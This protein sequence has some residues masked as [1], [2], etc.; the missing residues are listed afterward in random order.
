M[1]YWSIDQLLSELAISNI[2]ELSSGF[3]FRGLDTVSK[4]KVFYIDTD[5]EELIASKKVILQSL[6]SPGTNLPG[7]LELSTL[8]ALNEN[9][10]I[11]TVNTFPP[12]AIV[13][14]NEGLLMY[15]GEAEKIKLC[16]VI[17]KVLTER[18]GYWITGD[19]YRRST[20]EKVQTTTKD[21]LKELVDRQ[22][23]E[24]NMFDN[25][26]SAETFFSQQGFTIDKVAKDNFS[27]ISSLQYL[28][29]NATS[30]QLQ[31]MQSQPKIQETWRLKV[32][33]G[34]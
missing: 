14:V 31:E 12:G 29:R 8:N 2:L 20:L 11:K 17:R 16:Q 26:Q 21:N 4:K 33:D 27:K 30:V 19:I 1:R 23:I 10:F 7:K 15:L 13:I 24:E 6:H 28:M 3:S 25:F 18:G 5:L 9:E 22:K 34:L 32:K